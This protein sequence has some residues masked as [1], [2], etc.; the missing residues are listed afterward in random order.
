MRLEA[1][2]LLQF[3]KKRYEADPFYCLE[4]IEREI[5]N[6][7]SSA[8]EKKPL[9][10]RGL[11]G[12]F[13]ILGSGLAIAIAVFIVQ[14]VHA[15]INKQMNDKMVEI[16]PKTDDGKIK[17]KAAATA[18]LPSPTIIIGNNVPVPAAPVIAPKKSINSYNT[19]T[20]AQIKTELNE[21]KVIPR[22]PT[23]PVNVPVVAL[24]T[25]S[26]HNPANISTLTAALL[27]PQWN[28]SYLSVVSITTVVS[29][30]ITQPPNPGNSTLSTST[31]LPAVASPS[32]VTVPVITP[33]PTASTDKTLLM[34]A[35]H[36]TQQRKLKL[37]ESTINQLPTA[38]IKHEKIKEDAAISTRIAPTTVANNS[39]I[40]QP[41]ATGPNNS[42]L[43]E[44]NSKI[45]QPP[46]LVT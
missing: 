35:Q 1:A 15:Y 17:E 14:F 34:T 37:N 11:S 39:P 22:P 9:T 20:P 16:K 19:L 24:I 12:A 31:Q 41:I 8:N 33:S 7:K 3:W 21:S 30:I 27:K 32:P 26:S 4:K 18:K 2:G 38:Q 40:T 45:V 6:E 10:L 28:E 43:A 44:S 42:D 23:I 36:Q 46:Q 25:P 5:R 13:L 29:A